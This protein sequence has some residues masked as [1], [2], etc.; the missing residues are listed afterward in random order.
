[1]DGPLVFLTS[2]SDF[3][4]TGRN[5]RTTARA[6]LV[7]QLE[8]RNS[9]N[10]SARG[11]FN[12]FSTTRNLDRKKT[13]PETASKEQAQTVPTWKLLSQNSAA[14]NIPYMLGPQ[15]IVIRELLT[16]VTARIR[17]NLAVT[18]KE[19]PSRV[20]DVLRCRQWASAAF[21]S[22]VLCL[23]PE[24]HSAVEY[25]EHKLLATNKSGY[26]HTVELR[27]YAVALV[28]LR[29]SLQDPQRRMQPS[30]LAASH[31]LA[32]CEMLDDAIS[33]A[34][35]KFANG[36]VTLANLHACKGDYYARSYVHARAGAILVEALLTKRD[37]AIL[38]IPW[39]QTLVTAGDKGHITPEDASAFSN[40]ADLIFAKPYWTQM[41]TK[42]DVME[43]DRLVVAIR[44]RELHETIKKMVR[45]DLRSLNASKVACT[46]AET[47]SERVAVMLGLED[48]ISHIRQ[49]DE[50]SFALADDDNC[51]FYADVILST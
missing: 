7:R 10:K 22:G 44:A 49:A 41:S 37:D 8:S 51:S 1:M 26:S 33:G 13:L 31:I 34:Y 24:V 30:V 40:S 48:L 32:V 4:P 16:T 17:L 28:E 11:T 42:S 50:N 46:T 12:V 9:Q 21:A 15:S 14:F 27:K 38:D 36:M 19:Q 43:T 45:S 5:A 35:L 6:S 23:T 2:T 39:S 18:L 20:R 3:V 29:R 25:L 47:L